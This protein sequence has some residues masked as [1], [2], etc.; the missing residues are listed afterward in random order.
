MTVYRYGTV[1]SYRNVR[2]VDLPPVHAK[3]DQVGRRSALPLPTTSVHMHSMHGPRAPCAARGAIGRAAKGLG[4]MWKSAKESK[5]WLSVWTTV[6][7]L[8]DHAQVGTPLGPGLVW[9]RHDRVAEN[10][11]TEPK[12]EMMGGFSRDERVAQSK[13]NSFKSSGRRVRSPGS[14]NR[15]SAY[16]SFHS[17]NS[18]NHFSPG[19]DG[20]TSQ[21]SGKS[22]MTRNPLHFE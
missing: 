17:R 15:R 13:I 1:L 14:D 3:P 11:K 8:W 16:K 18:S 2:L 22:D 20:V 10:I 6:W 12:E 21:K 7:P 9:L 19:S 5:D 4:S